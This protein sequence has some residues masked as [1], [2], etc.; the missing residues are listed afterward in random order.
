MQRASP[1][2]LHHALVGRLEVIAELTERLVDLE[3][4]TSSGEGVA[5][6]I[7]LFEQRL[8]EI[9]F[10]PRVVDV[11]LV[12]PV[13]DAVLEFGPGPTVLVLGHADTVWPCGTA[14]DWRFARSGGRWSGPGVGDMKA[15]LALAAAALEALVEVAVPTGGTVRFLVIPDEEA[16]SIASRKT[17]EAA[18]STASVCLTLEAARAYGGLVTSR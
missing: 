4:P 17:I 8:R 11:G 16:G 3:S 18:A 7:G 1:Q 14:A 15:C 10:V 13:L 12:A 6:V 2:Q 5:A 9:G